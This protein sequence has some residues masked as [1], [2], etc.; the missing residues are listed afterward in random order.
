[1]WLD[2]AVT[3]RDGNINDEILLKL[4][5]RFKPLRSD[6]RFKAILRKMGLPED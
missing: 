1:V 2:R 3:Y 6:P 4:D 5:P